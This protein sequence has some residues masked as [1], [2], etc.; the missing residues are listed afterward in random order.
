MAVCD[1]CNREMN[2]AASCVPEPISFGTEDYGPIPFGRETR[3]RRQPAAD[4][5]C[6]D[7]GV[8]NGGMHHEG[9]DVEECPRCHGQLLSCDCWTEFGDEGDDEE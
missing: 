5:C 4:G 9:C 2:E 3:F 1:R 8:M 6:H 7:C